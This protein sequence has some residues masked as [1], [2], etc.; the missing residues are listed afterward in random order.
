[1]TIVRQFFK[2]LFCKH[3]WRTY[4]YNIPTNVDHEPITIA[5]RDCRKCAKW[6]LSFIFGNGK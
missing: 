5:F 1:M 2:Q 3:N 4:C 6:K